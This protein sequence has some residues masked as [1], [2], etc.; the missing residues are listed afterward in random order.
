MN[1]DAELCA[2]VADMIVGDHGV[3]QSP[4]ETVKRIADHG[5]ADMTDVHGLGRI[6]TGIVDDH[7]LTLA[8]ARNAE[9]RGSREGCHLLCKPGGAHGQVDKARSCDL[10]LFDHVGQGQCL[11]HGFSQRARRL[12]ERLGQRHSGIALEIAEAAIRRRRHADH[13]DIQVRTA[14]GLKR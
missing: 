5:G 2:P 12:L 11:D 10:Q 1:Q 9:A 7:G 13:A 3:A 14:H 6:R 4:V 8:H